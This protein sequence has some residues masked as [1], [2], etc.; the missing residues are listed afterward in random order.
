MPVPNNVV[1]RYL[2]V[3]GE[4]LYT[5]TFGCEAPTA[6]VLL[7][8]P[9]P[10][11][12]LH[13]LISWVRW[14]RF[15]ARHNVAAVR[16]DYRGTGESTGDFAGFG[17]LD[18]QAD[19]QHVAGWAES[20]WPKLPL[21]LHGL[22]M[23]GLLAQQVF[24]A[25]QGDGLLMWSAPAK[26]RDV[27]SQALILRLSMDMVFH[28]PEERKT[29]Q[30]YIELLNAGQAIEVDGYRWSSRLWQSAEGM[31]LDPAYRQPG[32]GTEPQNH[33][34]WKHIRLDPA[35]AP[36]IASP[37]Q[38][39]AMNPRAYVP[40]SPLNPDFAQFF[41]ENLVWLKGELR[42]KHDICVKR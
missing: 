18:W 7:C 31:Q 10:S 39:R 9:F 36:L 37:S 35:K 6:V 15:L 17:L 24:S 1:G 23:G 3:G 22:G 8:G 20:T 5:L 26:G 2:E 33:R 34:P 4:Q 30:Q 27:L 29:A 12:R 14:G 28:R 42:A 32:A 38:W 25:G 40:R 13:S 16:F 21:L 19:V 11:D 41:E